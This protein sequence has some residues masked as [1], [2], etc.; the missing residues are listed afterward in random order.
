MR[1]SHE[2]IGVISRNIRGIVQEFTI[3]LQK[4]KHNMWAENDGLTY[5]GY[6]RKHKHR[7]HM[8]QCA[9]AARGESELAW[10]ETQV[11]TNTLQYAET[12]NSLFQSLAEK[13]PK[14]KYFAQRLN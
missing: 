10:D 13:L 5:I 7:P 9:D 12:I 3:S 6:L 4:S 2:K 11:S 8:K 1:K 14:H